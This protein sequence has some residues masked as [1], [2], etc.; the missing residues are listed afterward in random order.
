MGSALKKFF[1][2]YANFKDRTTRKDFWMAILGLILCGMAL[3]FV[4]GFI[5][6]FTGQ[7]EN[8]NS[9]S[10]IVGGIASLAILVPS[11]AQVVRRLHDVN[12]SGWWWF[13]CLVPIIGEIW[14]LVLECSP[15]VTENNNYGVQL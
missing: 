11:L 15:S 13:I 7:E 8:V 1:M 9:L 2:N 6:G 10:T 12:K 5:A 4:T 3:G 14:L